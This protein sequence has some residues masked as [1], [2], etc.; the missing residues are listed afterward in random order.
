VRPG[1]RRG[2]A[3]AESH[4]LAEQR[5]VAISAPS[6]PKP[7]GRGYGAPLCGAR[8]VSG[9][10]WPRPSRRSAPR[11]TP[12]RV[13]RPRRPAPGG[14]SRAWRCPLPPPRTGRVR[15]LRAGARPEESLW[16]GSLVE[17]SLPAVALDE[18]AVGGVGLACR[19]DAQL[20]V[21]IGRQVAGER[22]VPAADEDGG[23]RGDERGLNRCDVGTADRHHHR[24]PFLQRG[25]S[26]GGHRKTAPTAK[27]T[28]RLTAA[29]SERTWR[30]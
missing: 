21:E 22:T 18:R 29:A 30:R 20:E 23:D 25:F 28:G 3:Q 15:I 4:L 5:P 9:R 24:T 10:R 27:W 16:S 13:R 26:T 11:V 8:E 6:P 1:G 12:R 14:G 7:T 2:R 17:E 19:R